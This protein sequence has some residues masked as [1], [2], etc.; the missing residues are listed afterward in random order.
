MCSCMHFQ[1]A[2]K[3]DHQDFFLFSTQ[4]EKKENS[5][6]GKNSRKIEPMC[7][8]RLTKIWDFFLYQNIGLSKDASE[9]FGEVFVL[10]VNSPF[11]LVWNIW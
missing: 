1:K 8:R 2:R 4:Q 9:N 10:I 3:S 11:N 6:N 7:G 5:V